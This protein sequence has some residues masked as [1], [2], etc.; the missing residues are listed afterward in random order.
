M[1]SWT[2]VKKITLIRGTV[3]GSS[4][5]QVQ[6]SFKQKHSFLISEGETSYKIKSI[7]NFATKLRRTFDL[8]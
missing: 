8:F 1:G 7:N 3:G 4:F 5:N 6:R 2:A